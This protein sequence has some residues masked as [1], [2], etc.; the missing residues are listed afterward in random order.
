M[1]TTKN[2]IGFPAPG[3]LPKA[4]NQTLLHRWGGHDAL[5]DKG[6]LGVPGIVLLHYAQLRPYALTTG[7]TMFVLHWLD[8]KWTAAAPYPGY[9]TLAARMGFGAREK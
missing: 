1:I 5:F 2:L 3:Q 4:T 7:E 6:F 8:H 9:K